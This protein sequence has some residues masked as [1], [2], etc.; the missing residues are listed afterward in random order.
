[1]SVPADGEARTLRSSPTREHAGPQAVTSL[2]LELAAAAVKSEV[3]PTPSSRSIQYTPVPVLPVVQP[4]H[5]APS[6]L[7]ASS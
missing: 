4:V 3:A 2:R 6:P 1:M 7:T 5:E